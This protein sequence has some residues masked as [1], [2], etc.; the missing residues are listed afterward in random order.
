MKQKLVPLLGIAFVVA[1]ISTGVFYGLFVG[2]AQT[3]P[4]GQQHFSVVVANHALARGAVIQPGDI[5]AISWAGGEAPKGSFATP[6]QVAGVTVLDPIQ[7]NDPVIEG[8][9]ASH[10][11]IPAGMRAVS[12]HVTDSSGVVALLHPGYKVDVQ[13]LSDAN[14]GDVTLRTA[15]QNVEVLTVSPPDGG[16]PVVNLLV[17]PEDAE[18]LGLADSAARVRLVLRNP[19]DDSRR[20][21]TLLPASSLFRQ[22]STAGRALSPL[23][24]PKIST[25]LPLR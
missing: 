17:A 8:R 12:I 2:K 24:D 22:T 15:L 19:A 4:T 18:L 20:S 3:A 7:A 13:V 23:S 6:D 14:R 21:T 25:L 9:I 1:L 11:A 16:K 10:R 5:K